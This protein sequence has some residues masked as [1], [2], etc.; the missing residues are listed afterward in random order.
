[1]LWAYERSRPS[2]IA[3]SGTR[4]FCVDCPTACQLRNTNQ[5]HSA[6]SGSP[7]CLEDMYANGRCDEE[8]NIAECAYDGGD[9]S[10]AQQARSL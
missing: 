5:P 8:C 6:A 3:H 1:M 4:I 2:H 7:G 9:C 10:I